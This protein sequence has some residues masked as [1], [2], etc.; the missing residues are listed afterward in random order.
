MPE[1]TV[2]WWIDVTA[3]TPEDAIAAAYRLFPMT[4]KPIAQ[5][6]AT[7]FDVCPAADVEAAPSDNL[8]WQSIDLANVRERQL[9]RLAR[10]GI[11]GGK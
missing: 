11:K 9:A 10:R 3:E 4:T 1:Y 2:R 5:S 7:V 8:P 6:L